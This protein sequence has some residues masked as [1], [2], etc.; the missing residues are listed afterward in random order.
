MDMTSIVKNIRPQFY[1]N[2][3]TLKLEIKKMCNIHSQELL[4][5]LYNIM[6]IQTKI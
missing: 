3:I 1:E 6:K 5:I 2:K 4:L